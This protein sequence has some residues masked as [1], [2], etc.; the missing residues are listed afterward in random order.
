[1]AVALALVL[2]PGSA[3]ANVLADTLED[4]SG[5]R[6]AGKKL[7]DL[8]SKLDWRTTSVLRMALVLGLQLEERKDDSTVQGSAC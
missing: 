6:W 8:T 2:A 4:V 3:A 7:L 1:M 5:L